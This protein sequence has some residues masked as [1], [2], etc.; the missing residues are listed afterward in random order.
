MSLESMDNLEAR[1]AA[2]IDRKTKPPG[3]LGLLEELALRL[4]VIQGTLRPQIRRPTIVVFAADHGL[5]HAGV[6]P[7]PQVV[8]RQMVL[9]FA[10]GG[11]AIKGFSYG[12]ECQHNQIL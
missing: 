1:L 11:A 8:T 4:G 3:S 10:Q 2:D 5:A 7:Y 12:D 9:N 6:S